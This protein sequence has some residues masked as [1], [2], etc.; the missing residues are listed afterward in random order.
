MEK[1][2][3]LAVTCNE[4]KRWKKCP[5]WRDSECPVHLKS[6]EQT[7]SPVRGAAASLCRSDTALK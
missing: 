7:L 3:V 6:E 1:I 4:I 5:S 2:N